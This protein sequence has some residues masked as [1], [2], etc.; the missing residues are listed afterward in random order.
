MSDV[1]WGS[2]HLEPPKKK[3]VPMWVWGC[4]GGCMFAI[5]ALFVVGRIVGPKVKEWI[6]SLSKPEVQW[7]RL[8]EVLPFD[9]RP[10]SV[11][12]ERWPFPMLDIWKLQ[13]K[14]DDLVVFVFA[15]PASDSNGPWGEWLSDPK[16]SPMFSAQPG[17][18]EC[19]QG[20]L[21]VQGRELSSVRFTRSDVGTPITPAP[22]P[23]TKED[24]DEKR[25]KELIGTESIHGNG[26]DLDV[27]PEGSPRRVMLWLV[28]GKAGETV[29]DEEAKNFLAPFMIGPQH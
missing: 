21:V 28:R 1:D 18:F 8:A 2:D 22:V 27:T 10:A 19:T 12:I 25:I 14:E 6:D 13:S 26:L 9:E 3:K 24:A 4:G 7:P 11:D 17:T 5:G 29:S 15:P 20:T 16:K 23:D